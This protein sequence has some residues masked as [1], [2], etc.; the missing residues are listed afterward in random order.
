MSVTHDYLYL[1]GSTTVGRALRL[2]ARRQCQVWLLIA[3]VE[4]QHCICSYRSLLPY[5]TGRTPH[6]VHNIG[7]C[8]ICSGMLSPTWPN[9]DVLIQEALAG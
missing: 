8:T 7:D 3:E 4:G 6:I 9:T 5:L 2:Y 1:P